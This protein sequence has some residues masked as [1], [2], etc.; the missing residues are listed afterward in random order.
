MSEDG[1][2][3]AGDL[4]GNSADMQAYIDQYGFVGATEPYL[5]TDPTKRPSIY[6]GEK[7]N[8][9]S[10]SGQAAVS[11]I[12]EGVGP[13]EVFDRILA[14][15]KKWI[16]E[17]F[18]QA[19]ENTPGLGDLADRALK[20][21]ELEV[22]RQK[23]LSDAENL[24]EQQRRSQELYGVNRTPDP[25][26]SGDAPDL[27]ALDQFSDQ[28]QSNDRL[29]RFGALR[30]PDKAP[31]PPA[32]WWDNN[33]NQGMTWEGVN[34]ALA[35]AKREA[36]EYYYRDSSLPPAGE[37]PRDPRNQPEPE[38]QGITFGGPNVFDQQQKADRQDAARSSGE[39]YEVAPESD[40]PET[41]PGR[42]DTDFYVEQ[43]LALLVFLSP[44]GIDLDTPTRPNGVGIR[45]QG[46]SVINDYIMK[47]LEDQTATNLFGDM[48]QQIYSPWLAPRTFDRDSNS[49]I[50]DTSLVDQFGP[51]GIKYFRQG[52]STDLLSSKYDFQSR[53]LSMD[54]EALEARQEALF[55]AGFYE[56]SVKLED[57]SWGVLNDI[58]I[59]ANE[60]LLDRAEQFNIG[61]KD[62]D[63][64]EILEYYRLAGLPNGGGQRSLDPNNLTNQTP[65]LTTLSS[66]GEVRL[67]ADAMARSMLGRDSTQEEQRL[68]LALVHEKQRT[69]S[70]GRA[71]GLNSPFGGEVESSTIQGVS[72]EFFDDP[73]RSDPTDREADSYSMSTTMSQ[74]AGIINGTV[75]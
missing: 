64:T 45:S 25:G 18:D 56:D 27:S 40:V 47:A 3:E 12:G 73:S 7:E 75:T 71:T 35:D 30:R 33:V 5:D 17:L 37:N 8:Y 69:E 58:D 2:F 38:E 61:N 23:L 6:A 29:D 41:A 10:N 36:S 57:I 70:R 66:A 51:E 50:G 39:V 14:T 65:V 9:I 22:S 46:L 24:Q 74:F 20:V 31:W 4:I 55:L 49:W 59:R 19:L 60:A 15:T 54:S 48:T 26:T 34:R 42:A 43:A 63:I 68:I 11:G 21:A 53:F 72:S 28:T 13:L 1:Q 44:E 62:M 32:V 16:P 52:A 67:N